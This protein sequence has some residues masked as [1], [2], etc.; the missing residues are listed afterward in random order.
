GQYY[1][2]ISGLDDG[3]TGNY[4]GTLLSVQRRAAKGL[5]VSANYTWSHCIGDIVKTSQ[6]AAEYVIPGNRS[7]SRGNCGSDRRQSFNSSTVYQTPA[8]SNRTV[9]ML[10][11]GWQISAIV[12]LISGQYFD[13]TAGSD[14]ALTGAA[15]QR[16][17]Q[18]LSDPFA[19]NKSATQRLNPSAFATPMTG[20]YGTMG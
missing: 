14:R 6:T 12:K 15:G 18:V 11:S 4:H 10:F 17:N 8:F 16:T 9:K 2:A 13:V 3:G 19:A 7:S 5:T 20:P 1:G